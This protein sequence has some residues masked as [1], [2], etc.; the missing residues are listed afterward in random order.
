M[1]K[2]NPGAARDWHGGPPNPWP[3]GLSPRS[4]PKRF[5]RLGNCLVEDWAV[6][7]WLSYR[8]AHEPELR[9]KIAELLSGAASD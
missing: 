5:R 7:K 4:T 6:L 9:K 8:L 2:G 1:P 3:D